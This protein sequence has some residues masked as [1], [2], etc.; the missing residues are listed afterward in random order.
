M[1]EVDM[2]FAS[3]EVAFLLFFVSTAEGILMILIYKI[4]IPLLKYYALIVILQLL[5]C[6]GFS[7]WF[8]I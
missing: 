2:S 4:S 5:Y 7:F 8:N 6:C 1:E 3:F